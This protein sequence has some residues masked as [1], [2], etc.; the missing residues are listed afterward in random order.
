MDHFDV[1]LDGFSVNYVQLSDYSII[2]QTAA[3][4]IHLIQYMC[5]HYM[6]FID[7]NLIELYEYMD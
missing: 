6:S 3:N 7:L 4:S 1:S 2:S 5:H